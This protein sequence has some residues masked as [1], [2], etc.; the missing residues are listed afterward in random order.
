MSKRRNFSESERE[1]IFSRAKSDHLKEKPA[2]LESALVGFHGRS[3]KYEKTLDLEELWESPLEAQCFGIAKVLFYNSDKRDP[4][5]PK[6][7]GQQGIDKAFF[8]THEGADVLLYELKLDHLPPINTYFTT[9]QI[10]KYLK[11]SEHYCLPSEWAQDAGWLGDLKKIE[12]ID[13]YKK[14]QTLVTHNYH[15]YMLEDMKT[16]MGLPNT[17]NVDRVLFWCSP[18]LK[19]NWRGII[20]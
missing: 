6:G 1:S 12:Y 13:V 18:D 3:L 10:N 7:E 16:L 17:D 14:P 11:K 4:A 20:N 2:S 5:D 9:T 15:L 19:V 8:H